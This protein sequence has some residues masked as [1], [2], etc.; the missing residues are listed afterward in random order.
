MFSAKPVVLT[1]RYAG[2]GSGTITV[3][4]ETAE[5]AF[6][7]KIDVNLPASQPEHDVLAPLWARKR[8]DWLMEQDWLGI[9]RGNP[10]RDVKGDITKLGLAFG[11]MTQ[12]T[13]FVAVEEKVVTEG[14]RPKTV[15]VPVEMPDGVSYEGI[16][17]KE[18]KI[19][20]AAGQPVMLG[21]TAS[22]A[23]MSAPPPSPARRT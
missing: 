13:S 1:G 21:I 10:N 22:A 3:R 17:G 15:E 6:E 18:A 8:I 11:L 19:L 5:G 4:G 14:G 16:F 12:Y 7:R 20:A 9:Q 2:S 23:P